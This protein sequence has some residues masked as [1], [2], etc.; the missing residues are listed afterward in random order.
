M[1]IIGEPNRFYLGRWG[2]ALVQIALSYNPIP[3]FSI[4]I[5]SIIYAFTF[6]FALE[7]FRL[8]YQ[9]SK[10]IFLSLSIFSLYHFSL[11]Q[12]DQVIIAVAIGDF[13]G[14][15]GLCLLISNKKWSGIILLSLA[16]AF[17]TSSIHLAAT[18]LIGYFIRQ[19]TLKKGYQTLITL[20]G[21]ALCFF[22]ALILYWV[23]S[24]ILGP[25][26][27]LEEFRKLNVD[28]LAFVH[29]FRHIIQFSLEIFFPNPVAKIVNFGEN[30]VIPQV[31][32][33]LY[34]A[35][36]I[37]QIAFLYRSR[38]MGKM[39]ILLPLLFMFLISPYFL[40]F[41][42]AEHYVFKIRSLYAFATLGAICSTLLLE[43]LLPFW[44]TNA[45]AR[46]GSATILVFALLACGLPIVRS[47]KSFFNLSILNIQNQMTT[48]SIIY[49]IE[50]L[51][52]EKTLPLPTTIHILTLVP[53]NYK[54]SFLSPVSEMENENPSTVA[55]N[56]AFSFFQGTRFNII[57]R[58]FRN[59][60]LDDPSHPNSIKR[61]DRTKNATVLKLVEQMEGAN[62]WPSLDS[63]VFL[64]GVVTI[65]Y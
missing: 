35:F 39:V 32:S 47:S 30:I 26:L 12:Y 29:R 44:S 23:Q 54:R 15:F 27:S 9:L 37:F 59:F 38:E 10:Y 5:A 50:D 36:A 64:D 46:Y 34:L 14:V 13:L 3:T 11:F 40:I 4:F 25:I 65:R 19:L 42:Q 52:G 18:L 2:N 53:D 63:V 51:F 49:R 43:Q 57:D 48:N 28:P 7:L 41:A 62:S 17:Y 56:T 24:K 31:S 33:F 20:A 6:F 1:F 60:V 8:K 21:L 22:S 55:E 58:L 61:S 16:P 45:A